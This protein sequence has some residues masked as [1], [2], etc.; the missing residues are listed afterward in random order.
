MIDYEYNGTGNIGEKVND[1]HY[2]LD[3]LDPHHRVFLNG[4]R[5]CNS[6]DTSSSLASVSNL[7][8]AGLWNDYHVDK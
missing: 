1:T 3:H 7:A 8:Q 6:N 4:H 5:D 2:L